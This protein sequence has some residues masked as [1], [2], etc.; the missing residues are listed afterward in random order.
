MV[1]GKSF[2][3]GDRLI[4][5]G[6]VN[7]EVEGMGE[8]EMFSTVSGGVN[9]VGCSWELVGVDESAP[10]GMKAGAAHLSVVLGVGGVAGGVLLGGGW[11]CGVIWGGGRGFGC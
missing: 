4:L 2:T 1:W 9:V 5:R 7:G 3:M 11:G 6:E 10:E 8:W